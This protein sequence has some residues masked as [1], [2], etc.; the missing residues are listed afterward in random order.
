LR[1]AFEQGRIYDA[2]R[3]I[4]TPLMLGL[5]LPLRDHATDDVIDL[6]A[7]Q[8][9]PVIAWRLDAILGLRRASGR[10]LALWAA[11]GK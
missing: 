6:I 11:G 9:A 4:A 3:P 7:A 5:D 10:R 8:R 2:L 1:I